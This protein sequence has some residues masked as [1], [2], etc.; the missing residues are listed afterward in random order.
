MI[1]GIVAIA[2]AVLF[3]RTA[4]AK[5]APAL[6]WGMVGVIT[7]YVPNFLW[8]VMVAKP[9]LTNLHKATA[10]MKYSFWGFSSVLIGLAAAA[11]VWYF[12]LNKQ[13]TAE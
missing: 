11:T 10:P 5:G 7:Y 1:G 4:V 2:L 6:Q 9:V 12:F 13:K 3:Y 8:S